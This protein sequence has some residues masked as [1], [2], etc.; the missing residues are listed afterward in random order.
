MEGEVALKDVA[1]LA[2][3]GVSGELLLGFYEF[4]VVTNQLF[5]IFNLGDSKGFVLGGL[6]GEVYSFFFFVF[7][8]FSRFKEVFG[9]EAEWTLICYGRSII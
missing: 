9:E 6:F 2:K 5:G 8:V 4:V 7:V 1:V 3:A